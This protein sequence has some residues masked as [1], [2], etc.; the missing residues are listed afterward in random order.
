MKSGSIPAHAASKGTTDEPW[1][2]GWSLLKETGRQWLDNGAMRLSAAIAY[3]SIF[4]IAPL[5]LLALALA[6]WA[7]GGEAA[8]G[9]LQVQLREV[10]GE[11]AA[12]AVLALLQSAGQPGA[13]RSA[14]LVGS[15]F[16][17]L[18]ASGVF[19]QLKGALNIIWGVQPKAHQGI[20]GILRD[21]LLAFAMVLAIGL[22]LLASV[23][24]GIVL[25][26]SSQWVQDFLVLPRWF[27]A[28]VAFLV[29][30]DMV[31]ALFAV[32]FKVLPDAVVSWRQV[33]LGAAVTAL[34]FEAGKVLLSLYLGRESTTSGY[35]AAQ[36][37]VLVLLWGNYASAILLFGAQFTK[38]H[39]TARGGQVQPKEHAEAVICL[40][41]AG[42]PP[43]PGQGKARGRPGEH[44]AAP[45]AHPLHPV[46]GLVAATGCGLAMGWAVGA[47][48]ERF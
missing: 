9:H 26:S 12:R 4:S 46:A 24:V 8:Q 42:A 23:L 43:G 14:T 29:S 17:L 39:A 31:A 6:G 41:K 11:E 32:I 10:L 47:A 19:A 35:G 48:K 44:R 37:L 2:L 25:G 13:G 5:L 33:W 38:V 30:F 45:R 34:F 22:L 1:R 20:T 7:F 18:G 40:P 21:R 27:W 36:S 15:A 28:V 3:Y 16:L